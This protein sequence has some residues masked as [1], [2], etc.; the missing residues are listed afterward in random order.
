MPSFRLLSL[1]A[2]GSLL[3]VPALAQAVDITP[4]QV[5][6]YS[7][8]Y[9]PGGTKVTGT[10]PFQFQIVNSANQVQWDSGS[11]Q[12][13]VFTGEFVVALGG[14]GMPPLPP[15]L[16][17]MDNLKLLIK[18]NGAAQGTGLGILPP[19]QILPTWAFQPGLNG[20]VT[21]LPNQ[22]KVVKLLGQSIDL[23]LPPAAG[24]TLIY[25]GSLW[26]L[27]VAAPGTQGPVGPAGPAG[28]QGPTGPQGV[29][30]VNGLAGPQGPQGPTGPMGPAGAA[31]AT[32]AQGAM[33]PMGPV[34]PM[35]PMGPQGVQGPQGP[36]GDPGTPGAPGPAGQDGAT[37]ISG[38]GNPL[39][40]QGG[41]AFLGGKPGDFYLDSSTG[42][43]YGP[44]VAN[45]AGDWSGA[46]ALVLMGAQGDPGPQGP[47]GPQGAAGPAGSAGPRGDA[48][49]VGPAGPTG[50]LGPQGPQGAQGIKGDAGPAGPA[51]A[52]GAAGTSQVRFWSPAVPWLPQTGGASGTVGSTCL[53][54]DGTSFWGNDASGGL[55]RLTTTATVLQYF[56]VRASILAFD[57]TSVWCA[58]GPS[59]AAVNTQ[60]GLNGAP[61]GANGN[62]LEMVFDG[63]HM[64]VATA[65]S[66]SIMS[67]ATTV[68]SH[69]LSLPPKSLAFDGRRMWIADGS[70]A[71]TRLT[72][73]GASDGPSLA[74]STSPQRLASEG[75]RLWVAGL[76]NAGAIQVDVFD[77]TS[78]A[79][80]TTFTTT[81]T[82]ASALAFDGTTMW[83]ADAG[84]GV[85]KMDYAAADR[86]ALLAA[87]GASVLAFD[88]VRMWCLQSGVLTPL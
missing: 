18:V 27:G 21:G 84:T 53:L 88:G 23:T 50:P 31:G 6:T 70:N 49:P 63:A 15:G 56:A 40:G 85:Y 71:L 5:L 4:Q 1:L 36:Q 46:S 43:L 35:G 51:G 59:I 61:P 86:S 58:S 16:A 25:N 17:T 34:G 74:V 8:T 69:A 81:A 68:G 29:P 37:L 2:A 48:G 14:A 72:P 57:G 64:W 83:L 22:T 11:V 12:L 60:T 45:A 42:I 3:A 26:Q 75:G 79:L 66:V 80:L 76:N 67:L 44:K 32:G 54:H 62:V 87:P 78:L 55:T 77:T 52:A 24:Q 39:P 33:G 7:G 9:T 30:G 13:S 28:P 20:E 41:S 47:V 10:Y 38:V 73:S 65:Q 19:L 82:G